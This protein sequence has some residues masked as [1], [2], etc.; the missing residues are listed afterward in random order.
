MDAYEERYEE[1]KSTGAPEINGWP[2]DV[3]LDERWQCRNVPRRFGRYQT[4]ITRSLS[5][6]GLRSSWRNGSGE[7]FCRPSGMAHRVTPKWRRTIS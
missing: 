6:A 3:R 7:G 1:F 2:I 5:A 4:I